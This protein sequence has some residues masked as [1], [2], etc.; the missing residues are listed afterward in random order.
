MIKVTP[1]LQLILYPVVAGDGG[2]LAAS[3]ETM[4]MTFC[5]MVGKK[6]KEKLCIDIA[7]L[8]PASIA[9]RVNG[10]ILK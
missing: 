10:G 3:V 1:S 5:T 7:G 4:Q 6:I 2:Y 8:L 9:E